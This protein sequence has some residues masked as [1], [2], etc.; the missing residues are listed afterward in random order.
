MKHQKLFNLLLFAFLV[1]GML[2][3]QNIYVSKSGNNNNSGA[4]EN[5][6]L[7][8]IQAAVNKANPGNTILV[9][10]GTYNEKITFQGN[11][12]SGSVGQYVTLQAASN[13]VV[14]S[15]SGLSASGRQGLV[16]I[17]NASYIKIIGFDIKDFQTSSSSQSPIG[18]YVVGSSSNIEIA[19][20]KVHDIKHNSTCSGCGVGAHG[21]GVFGTTTNGIKNITLRNNEVYNNVLQSSEAFVINGNVSGFLVKDNYVHDNNNIGFDFIGYEGECSCDESEDRVRNGLVIGNIAENNSSVGNPWYGNDASAGGFYV[22]GGTNIVFDRNISSGNDLGFEFASEHVGKKTEN[23]IMSNNLVFNNTEVGVAM[24]GWNNTNT[25][26]A[27]N[28]YVV[29]NTFYKN[30]NGW[31]TEITFQYKVKNATIAN[32]IIMGS[33]NVGSNMSGLTNS[34]NAN[35]TFNK[36]LWWGNSTSGQNNLPGS[37]VV[38][39]PMFKNPANGDFTVTNNSPAINA[40]Q[41][42]ASISSWSNAFWEEYYT[43]GTIPLSGNKDLDNNNR[44]KN[45][46]DLGA[47]EFGATVV[48]PPTA[49]AAPSNLSATASSTSRITLVWN[50]NADNETEYRIER[51]PGTG[52]NFSQIAIVN[53]DVTTYQDTNLTAGT[54]YSYRVIAHN[55]AGTSS[56]S[57]KVEATTAPISSPLPAPWVNGDIGNPTIQGSASY[58]NGTFTINGSGSD[59]WNNADQFHYMYQ[60]ITGDGEIVVKMNDITNTNNWAKAGVMIRESLTAGSKHAM[61]IASYSEGLGFQ[62]RV[63][64]NGGTT[65]TSATGT[66]PVWLKLTRSGD[67][68]SAWYS[69]NGTNWTLVDQETIAMN[70]EV[71]IGLA[72]TSHNNEELGTATFD[73]LSVQ[74]GTPDSSIPITVDG[75]ASDWSDVPSLSTSGNGGLTNLKAYDDGEYLYIMAQ[76]STNTNTIFFLNTDD[77]TATGYKNGLWSPEGSDYNIENGTLYTYTGSGTSWNWNNVSN[78]DITYV[79]NASVIELRI[80]KS[81]INNFAGRIGIG[82]DVE[83]SSWNTVATIPATGNPLAYYII[84]TSSAVLRESVPTATAELTTVAPNPFINTTTFE[85]VTKN[86][87]EATIV[88][89]NLQGNK[90]RTLKRT[91]KGDDI[92]T[93]TWKGNNR[94]GK[95]VPSGIYVAKVIMGRV[96]ESVKVIKR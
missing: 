36:N 73:N 53:A 94:K 45:T 18:I 93:Y 69:T 19:E 29:N 39:N 90:V 46:I 96:I 82:L 50:D 83:T 32:N 59:I 54:T 28:I 14:I 78:T 20:N 13:N 22:D 38:A 49:P 91:A 35:I 51:A 58:N 81:S 26:S 30:D 75:N 15:G 31:G 56:Y 27:E 16:N 62:R 5:N 84:E 63:S 89:Y 6:A 25:G 48:V 1:T 8:T 33:F 79:K 70:D 86:P 10:S 74:T 34:G 85:M 57:N 66:T 42:T 80:A 40:G 65:H 43:N 21:I 47:Y 55:T 88:I 23:I 12:D 60:L 92:Y 9:A 2:S 64:T 4:S 17:N 67:M 71:Y 41:A 7:L 77:D 11:A 52:N 44:I 24:G 68:I 3:A 72:M 61:L 76:G 87:K 37:K 95:T